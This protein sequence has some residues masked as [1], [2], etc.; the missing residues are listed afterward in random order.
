MHH[1]KDVFPTLSLPFPRS[2][3]ITTHRCLEFPQSLHFLVPL[4]I[5]HSS[6]GFGYDNIIVATGNILQNACRY[7]ASCNP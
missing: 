3:K 4:L 1:K 6:R 7:H 2:K 5:I